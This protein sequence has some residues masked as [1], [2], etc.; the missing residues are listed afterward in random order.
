MQ[1]WS[2]SWVLVTVLPLLQ[3]MALSHLL[4]RSRLP[5]SHSP[6][7]V[8]RIA[9]RRLRPLPAVATVRAAAV[10]VGLLAAAEAEVV[11]VVSALLLHLPP[12]AS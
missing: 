2:A 12:L 8:L 5:V 1:H 9:P 6:V 10:L 11:A 4:H 3:L 7:R